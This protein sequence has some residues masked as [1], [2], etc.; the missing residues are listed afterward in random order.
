MIVPLMNELPDD[1]QSK[2][3][4]RIAYGEAARLAEMSRFDH[5]WGKD[6]AAGFGG[7]E[8]DIEAEVTRR[9]GHGIHPKL[10]KMAVQDALDNRKPQW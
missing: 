5:G 2:L 1:L 4:Y 6:F 3:G 8:L 7:D 9:L 10:I